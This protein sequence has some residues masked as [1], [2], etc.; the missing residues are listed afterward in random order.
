[1]FRARTKLVFRYHRPNDNF[2]SNRNSPIHRNDR[3]TISITHR[4]HKQ[5][6]DKFAENRV[7]KCVFEQIS[8]IISKKKKKE[9]ANTKYFSRTYSGQNGA[10][11]GCIFQK[12]GGHQNTRFKSISSK[13]TRMFRNTNFQHRVLITIDFDQCDL[14]SWAERSILCYY[15]DVFNYYFSANTF[16]TR[17]N[18]N[19]P[20]CML[21]YCVCWQIVSS[22]NSIEV[23]SRYV[24]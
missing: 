19:Y 9:H 20:I 3:C 21:L 13:K 14:R 1:M 8:I 2:A 18:R 5:Y 17:Q 7:V 10:G 12:G 24:Y 22:R 23:I 15:N 16:S 11:G 6:F 4:E